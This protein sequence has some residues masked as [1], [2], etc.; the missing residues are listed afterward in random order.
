MV[1]L[2]LL[3][4]VAVL[5]PP[6]IRSRIEHDPVDSVG[7]FRRHLR[8]LESATPA[9]TQ[10][11]NDKPGEF[12]SMPRAWAREARRAEVLRHRRLV[13][14][15]FLA[16]MGTTLVLG[17]VPG[18]HAVLVVH[19]FLDAAFGGYLY[20]LAESR[21]RARLAAIEAREREAQRIAEESAISTQ[22]AAIAA[23]R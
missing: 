22:P 10:L 5:L 17:L 12:H 20:L 18:F 2:L 1:S 9:A 8:V 13:A 6:F 11:A 3:I 19:L 4:W 14:R 23:E 7:E 16:S 15:V 21:R